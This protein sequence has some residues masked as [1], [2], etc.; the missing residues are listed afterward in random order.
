ME[1]RK[2]FLPSCSSLI[3]AL[4]VYWLEYLTAT[5]KTGDQ[6]L[7]EETKFC[8]F[9]LNFQTFRRFCDFWGKVGKLGPFF[10][11][12]LRFKVYLRTFVKWVHLS[13]KKLILLI[14]LV[15]LDLFRSNILLGNMLKRSKRCLKYVAVTLSHLLFIRD[16]KVPSNCFDLLHPSQPLC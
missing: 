12:K 13:T 3:W 7:L 6:T 9:C 16:P 11:W 10:L 8:K 2:I 4:M 5:Q 15:I 14:K 1:L